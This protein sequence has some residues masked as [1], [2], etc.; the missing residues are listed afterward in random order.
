MAGQFLIFA[1]NNALVKFFHRLSPKWNF[2][3]S[4]LINQTAAR[5][6]IA[7]GVVG[8][9][10]SNFRAG[11]IRCAGLSVKQALFCDFRYIHIS[12]FDSVVFAEKHICRL[13]ISV[14][15]LNVV[16]DFDRYKSEKQSSEFSLTFQNLNCDVSY[17]LLVDVNP[18]L[19][20]VVYLLEEI[21]PI[22]VLHDYANM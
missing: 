3:R 12:Y 10:F 5:P 7:L 14:Q 15:N 13:Q 19:F 21:A 17:L 11:K 6:Y 20:M 1:L 18:L 22:S 8:F 2:E 4:H 9:L 16:E